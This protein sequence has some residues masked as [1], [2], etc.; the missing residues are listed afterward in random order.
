MEFIIEDFGFGFKTY[1]EIHKQCDEFKE[2]IDKGNKVKLIMN[3]STGL[4][5]T[6]CH[7]TMHFGQ[8]QNL[9]PH[10]MNLRSV[11]D[12]NNCTGY[13]LTVTL[14]KYEQPEEANR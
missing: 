10:H 12:D 7:L 5:N 6:M 9:S 8:H 11:A 3:H 13:H 2:M 4:N 1:D 14:F